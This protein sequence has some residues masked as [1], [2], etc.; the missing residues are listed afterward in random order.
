M[1]SLG[2]ALAN[3]HDCEETHG[4][5]GFRCLL[6]NEGAAWICEENAV[7][8][9]KQLHFGGGGQIRGSLWVIA[10]GFCAWG[11]GCLNLQGER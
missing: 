2:K 11:S 9:P 8:I 7:H 1:L 3:P 4:R 10:T 6:R 5:P